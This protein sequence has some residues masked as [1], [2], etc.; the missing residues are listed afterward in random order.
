[1]GFPTAND[2]HLGCFGGTTILGNLRMVLCFFKVESE[3]RG[4]GRS[5]LTSH[6]RFESQIHPKLTYLELI[7]L[8]PEAGCEKGIWLFK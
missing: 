2:Q 5:H 7:F 1:M 8:F 6:E 4:W 3:K